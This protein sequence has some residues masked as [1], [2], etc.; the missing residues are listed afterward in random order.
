MLLCF[1]RDKSHLVKKENLTQSISFRCVFFSPGALFIL[2]AR[3]CIKNN[4]QILVIR[5]HEQ[6]NPVKIKFIEFPIKLLPYNQ[7]IEIIQWEKCILL[8]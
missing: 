6:K 5:K 4:I 3:I 2:E 8:Y 7:V 1:N